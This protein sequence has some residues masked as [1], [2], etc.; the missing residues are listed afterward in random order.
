M[1]CSSY[2]WYREYLILYW[3]IISCASWPV[4]YN[5]G[6]I[7]RRTHSINQ[8]WTEGTP[9]KSAVSE[10]QKAVSGYENDYSTH[11]AEPSFRVIE[12]SVQIWGRSHYNQGCLKYAIC[13]FSCETN[14][15]IPHIVELFLLNYRP[16]LHIFIGKASV[17]TS[18]QP[19]WKIKYTAFISCNCISFFISLRAEIV[20]VT[21][22]NCIFN[23]LSATDILMNTKPVPKPLR[24]WEWKQ[25]ATQFGI[26][27]TS[28]SY[29][30][31]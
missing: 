10:T 26:G 2:Y 12:V 24:H 31:F 18:R 15:E 14:A 28:E 27:V 23:Y 21:G 13:A 16:S 25:I 3:E 30:F 5:V 22:C 17:L 4:E 20:Y 29:Y 11:P 9:W 19:I 1:V 6:L 7:P 8:R